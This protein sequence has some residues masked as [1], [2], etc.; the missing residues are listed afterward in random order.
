[1]TDICYIIGAGEHFDNDSPVVRTGDLIIAAD[2]GYSFLKEKNIRP[3]IIIGDFDSADCEIPEEDG[4]QVIRLNPVKDETD[5]LSA[6]LKGMEA[7]YRIFHIYGG[8]GGRTD[9]TIANIQTLAMLAQ[10]GMQGFLFGKNEVMTVIHN[11]SINFGKE[12]EGY[13]SVF[14]LSTQS[15]GVTIKGL[16]YEL[17]GFTMENTY[18]VGVSNEF[19]GNDSYVSVEDGT[20]LVIYPK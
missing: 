8:T 16:K 5:T 11:S 18:P 4:T 9:H 17:D 3:G 13:I 15:R 2:G 6:V 7:G 20:L 10:K 1:M 19:T 14:T 12:K